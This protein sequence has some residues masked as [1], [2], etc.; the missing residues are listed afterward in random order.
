MFEKFRNK[1][2][3]DGT[4]K[5]LLVAILGMIAS[6][7]LINSS[8]DIINKRVVEVNSSL[9]GKIISKHPELEGEIVGNLTREFQDEYKV[10]GE[11]VLSKYGYDTMMNVNDNKAF[12]TIYNEFISI[13]IVI[14]IVI[15]FAIYIV[16]YKSMGN[17]YSDITSVSSVARRVVEGDFNRVKVNYSEGDVPV[18]KES[19]NLM[20]ESLEKNI[21]LLNKEKNFLNDL[22]SDI[23]HQLKTPL[24]SLIMF[25]D[26]MDDLTIEDVEI[27]DDCVKSSREQLSR[28]EWL[29]QNLLKL[30]RLESGSIIF[31]KN[32]CNI[33]GTL[34]KSIAP[35]KLLSKDGQKIILKGDLDVEV[36]HDSYWT[37]EALSNIIKNAVEHSPED[38]KVIVRC[39]EGPIFMTIKVIDE[40]AGIDEDD[41]KKIFARF[42]R[43]KNP[44]NTNSIGIGLSLAKSIIDGQDGEIKVTSTKDRGT[45]FTITM[46]KRI[47]GAI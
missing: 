24:S 6:I 22:I 26:L 9:V 35:F 23:T 37:S 46:Y 20:V 11:E 3:I 13:Y 41:R 30:A 4:K 14:M 28:M 47:Q 36:N 45:T 18:L 31:Q 21:S 32:L 2:I 34:E 17:V 12:T 42:Y 19:F 33:R 8:V 1:E 7:A 15:I 40:G 25:N 44:K 43:G 5:I 27:L 39:E 10:L 29:V 16:F 38:S